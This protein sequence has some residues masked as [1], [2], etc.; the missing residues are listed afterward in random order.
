MVQA[1]E[2]SIWLWRSSGATESLEGRIHQATAKSSLF[3]FIY[4]GRIWL[5]FFLASLLKH[6]YYI[7]VVKSC[8]RVPVPAYR[9]TRP[10]FHAPSSYR[11]TWRFPLRPRWSTSFTSHES[12]DIRPSS[13]CLFWPS[14]VVQFDPYPSISSGDQSPLLVVI[15]VRLRHF[16]LTIVI[17]N[18]PNWFFLR[19]VD[20]TVNCL[21]LL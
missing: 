10:S 3:S 20:V 16:S 11:S 14:P 9:R 8:S 19:F 4:F 2:K 21:A 1:V 7:E 13:S 18:T 15:L 12:T 17:I 6:D 5:S